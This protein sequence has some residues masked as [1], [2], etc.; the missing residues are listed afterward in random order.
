M[1][2]Y[3]EGIQ[4]TTNIISTG[5]IKRAYQNKDV[6]KLKE[7]ADF[8]YTACVKTDGEIQDILGGY[9]YGYESK[10]K[11]YGKRKY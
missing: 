5:E 7:L 6:D 9:L 10:D 2:K 8:Y 4:N 3:Q 11:R 1:N